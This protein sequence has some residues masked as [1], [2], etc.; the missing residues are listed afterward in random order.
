MQ[1]RWWLL[2]LVGLL[3]GVGLALFIMGWVRV[4]VVNELAG[5][6]VVVS[7]WQTNVYVQVQGYG[8]RAR[9][10]VARYTDEVQEGMRFT[11]DGGVVLTSMG[12]VWQ[13]VG[14]VEVRSQYLEEHLPAADGLERDWYAYL[15][16]VLDAER[17]DWEACYGKADAYLD[18]WGRWLPGR[19][20]GLKGQ[21]WAQSCGGRIP[22]GGWV[23]QCTCSAGG[24][25]CTNVNGEC[26]PGNAGRCEN[27]QTVCD[28][29]LNNINCSSLG[30]ESQCNSLGGIGSCGI[31]CN[32]SADNFCSW[33]GGGTTGCT[34]SSQCP[35]SQCCRG[36][37]CRSNCE[38]P[39]CDDRYMVNC[40]LGTTRQAQILRTDCVP[41]GQMYWCNN[42]LGN[43]QTYN[44][45]RRENVS[46]NTPP[47]ECS[48]NWTPSGCADECDQWWTNPNTGKETC[49][50]RECWEGSWSCD[51]RYVN[52]HACTS[53]CA[54]TP[55]TNVRIT[56]GSTYATA[57]LTWTPGS[58]G[59]S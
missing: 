53:P 1:K 16:L 47:G 55:P 5:R 9:Q 45:T 19:A 59:E 38:G 56:L 7:G 48:C 24:A 31:S 28:T 54:V 42:Y 58:G 37:V 36:G 34:T 51:G 29:S 4:E 10:I 6:E 8:G 11:G 41:K 35:G 50:R 39:A 21:A 25:V 15:C 26:G 27:C 57:V 23:N 22:C 52:T 18:G 43:A 44:T 12:A 46:G 2:A 17:H 33:G 32:N 30:S 49:I 14:V 3:I 40:P 13:S 20:A